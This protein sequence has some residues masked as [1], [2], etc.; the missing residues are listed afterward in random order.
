VQAVNAIGNSTNSNSVMA[1]P[2]AAGTVDPSTIGP[3]GQVTITSTGWKASS[4][5]TAELH[6]TPESL[7]TL[8]ADGNGKISGQVTIPADAT[9]GAHSIV[10]TGTD[11]TSARMVTLGITVTAASSNPGSN[12]GSGSATPGS[13]TNVS[14]ASTTSAG[15]G[16]S[17]PFTGANVRGFV[18]FALLL[19]AA[20]LAL[21]SWRYRR[22]AAHA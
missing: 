8:T 7:G 16:S 22:R 14:G 10:L 9:P 6:S 18:S 17:L 11:P 3:G 20:G 5:V 2:N 13:G 12:P 19:I 15:T 1:T 21:L 4:Q